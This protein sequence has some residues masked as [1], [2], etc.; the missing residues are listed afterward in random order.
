MP[1]GTKRA[2]QL[3]IVGACVGL[4]SVGFHDA[5]EWLFDN[6]LKRAAALSV[7]LFLVASFASVVGASALASWLIHR[8]APAAGGGGVMPTKIAFWKDFGV[9]PLRTAVVKFFGSALT[10]GGGVSMGP[11]GPAVQIG[12]ASAS[13]LGGW[14]GVAKQE[15][16]GFCACGAAAALAAA[17]NAP[18]AA[19][20]F[21]LEEIIGDLNSRLISGILLAAVMGALVAHALVGAQP[22]YQVAVLGEPSWKGLLLCLLVAVVS[23]VAGVA[24]QKGAMRLRGA[25]KTRLAF[26]PA[27]FKP[28]VGAVFSWAIA[29]GVFI[30]CGQLG[31]FGIGYGDVTQAIAGHLT[32]TAVLLLFVGK[33]LATIFAV[34]TGGCGG[35]FAPSFFIGAMSG[36]VVVEVAQRFTPLPPA[37]ASILVMIGMCACLGAVIRTPLTCVLLIFEVTHQFSIV[38]FAL[39]ATLVSQVLAHRLQHAGMYEEM[40]R[41]DGLS[42]ERVLPPRDYRRWKEMRVGAIA[43]YEVVTVTSRDAASLADLLTRSQHQRFPVIDPEEKVV[44]VATRDQIQFALNNSTALEFYPAHW[45]G[46]SSTLEAAQR[47]ILDAHGDCLCVGDSGTGKLE[48][49]L[50]LHDFL[51]AQQRLSDDAAS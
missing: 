4:V 1:P 16:R 51:R 25:M 12:A 10:L 14:L 38:P 2:F 44:G 39:L 31:V 5:V 6:G 27:A 26:L 11:E 41:Q 42:P 20:L 40:L 36:A 50:T 30:S 13:A 49:I 18:L 15:R 33:L 46:A 17:F 32:L 3:A 48:G 8:F 35:I 29:A 9:I 21:I 43:Q 19:I 34:G 45:I 24:F 22:A 23:T 7:P 28:T 47:A 37:D